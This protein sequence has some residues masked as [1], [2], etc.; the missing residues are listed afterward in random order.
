MCFVEVRGGT[1]G[2]GFQ[3]EKKFRVFASVVRT[4]PRHFN[5][6]LLLRANL[7]NDTIEWRHLGGTNE[8][9]GARLFW[10]PVG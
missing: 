10:Y 9:S 3:Q 4:E 7:L 5:G 2:A 1:R 8:L 6:E